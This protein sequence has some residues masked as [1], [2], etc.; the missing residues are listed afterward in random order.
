MTSC[1]DLRSDR[2]GNDDTLALEQDA[3]MQRDFIPIVPVISNWN[4][5]LTF[6]FRPSYQHGGLQGLKNYILLCRFQQLS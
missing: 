3:I 5:Y 2:L 1:N 4:R 6:L